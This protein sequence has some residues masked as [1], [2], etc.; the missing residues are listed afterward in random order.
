MAR[1]HK[2]GNPWP[3]RIGM[4]AERVR[5][6]GSLVQVFTCT[7]LMLHWA[8]YGIQSHRCVYCGNRSQ[9]LDHL[10]PV[11]RGGPHSMQNLVPAC[12]RCN[13]SKGS[14]L[15]HQWIQI[16]DRIAYP[17]PAPVLA[18][19]LR[20]YYVQKQIDFDVEAALD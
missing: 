7:D 14:L 11:R 12:I 1:R 13:N 20:S 2:K 18:L 9:T 4:S 15:L 6:A 8:S 16:T 3:R 5:E 19:T 17:I 10:V